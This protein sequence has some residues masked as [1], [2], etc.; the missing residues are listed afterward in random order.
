MPC[1][2]VEDEKRQ[3]R[4]EVHELEARVSA[5]DAEKTLMD[6]ERKAEDKDRTRILERA[7]S[8]ER[9]V[10]D[11]T[12]ELERLASDKHPFLQVPIASVSDAEPCDLS[13]KL[14][15]AQKEVDN[16][17]Y[18]YFVHRKCTSSA[19]LQACLPLPRCICR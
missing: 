9:Q 4:Q 13:Q 10:S 14:K 17:P 12:S 16:H 1:S 18:L 15:A 3:R 8:A 11:L 19:L 6:M 7:E 2:Q 5:I